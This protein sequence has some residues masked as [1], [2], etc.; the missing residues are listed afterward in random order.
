MES[1]AEV[2]RPQTPSVNL[3]CRPKE[4]GDRVLPVGDKAADDGLEPPVPAVIRRPAPQNQT[5]EIGGCE[6]EFLA[7][8]DAFLRH[9][10]DEETLEVTPQ[11]VGIV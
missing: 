8:V 5:N 10:R 3:V 6:V 2:G 4:T 7:V 1:E 9:P 11:P